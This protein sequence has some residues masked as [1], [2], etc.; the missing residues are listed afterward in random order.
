MTPGGHDWKST[1]KGEHLFCR[2]CG[3]VYGTSFAQVYQEKCPR[4]A[5]AAKDDAAN[6]FDDRTALKGN[7]HD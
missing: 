3:A 5:G 6:L 1:E 7:P 2:Y 4:A